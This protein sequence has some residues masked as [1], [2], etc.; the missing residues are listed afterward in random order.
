M[1]TRPWRNHDGTHKNND[2]FS[3][4]Y[5]KYDVVPFVLHVN[6]NKESVQANKRQNKYFWKQVIMET[7]RELS[8]KGGKVW[9]SESDC[10]C[11]TA[12]S[13]VRR[14]YFLMSLIVLKL[15]IWGTGLEVKGAVCLF[16]C[17]HICLIDSLF[18]CQNV[19]K[20]KSGPQQCG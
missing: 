17:L 2:T 1:S 16:I 12:C 8:L 14:L 18:L 10:R 9:N 5:Y 15:C 19:C 20:Q 13:H 6:K 11:A 3:I 4:S 7:G